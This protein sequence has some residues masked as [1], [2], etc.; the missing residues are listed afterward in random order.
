[1][2]YKQTCVECIL[3]EYKRLIKEYS[4]PTDD[5]LVLRLNRLSNNERN[6][7]ILYIASDYKIGILARLLST[8]SK[9]A[10]KLVEEIQNK[11]KQ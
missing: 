10:K 11:L 6:I 4:M 5:E 8:N 7:I 2:K 3:D 9:Y 1:M